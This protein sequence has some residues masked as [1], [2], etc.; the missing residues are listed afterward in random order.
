LIGTQ[1]RQDITSDVRTPADTFR[2]EIFLP[3]Y[4]D[5]DFE[6][7]ERKRDPV[8]EIKLTD[9]EIKNMLPE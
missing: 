4:I 9:E 8:H 7:L 1:V 2:T 3:S 6:S 5:C